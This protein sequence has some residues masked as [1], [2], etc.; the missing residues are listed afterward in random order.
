M[1]L[2]YLLPTILLLSSIVSAKSY[3]Y[4]TDTIPIPVRS[5]NKIQNKPSNLLMM[6]DSGTKLELL[7]SEN[8]WTK[9]KFENTIGWVISR[10]LTSNLPT[11]IQ[12]KELRRYND[13]NKFLLSKQNKKN[14]KLTAKVRDLS[15][16]NSALLIEN[17]K[18]KAEK[19][20]IQNTYK[21]ALQLEHHNKNLESQILQMRSELQLSQN[22][23]NIEQDSSLRNWFI[24]GAIVLFLG[25]LMGFI[26]TKI[27]T[28]KRRF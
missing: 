22:S 14:K 18:F 26:F 17:G 12:L 21:N 2:K 6:L 27:T 23:N 24:V 4:I 11:K 10:Y 19:K 9:V 7:S 13:S 3:V 1:K 28:N 16:K 8:G 15:K 5:S 25:F 20:H